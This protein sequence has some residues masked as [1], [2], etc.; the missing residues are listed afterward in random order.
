MNTLINTTAAQQVAR[1]TID[2]RVRDAEQRRLAR[3]ARAERRTERNPQA[4]T[5][6]APVPWWGFRFLHPAH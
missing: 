3:T 4:P 6:P 5:A 1:Y 2:Q